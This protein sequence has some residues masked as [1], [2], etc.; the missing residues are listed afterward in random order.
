MSNQVPQP[1]PPADRDDEWVA[2]VIAL[3]ALA[4]LLGWTV[5][6]SPWLQDAQPRLQSRQLTEQ[7]NL[8]T[9]PRGESPTPPPLESLRNQAEVQRQSLP[10]GKGP[11]DSGGEGTA[12]TD[13]SSPLAITNAS[14][15]Q[16]EPRSPQQSLTVPAPSVPLSE[17]G[18][19]S[20]STPLTPPLVFSDLP[21]DYWAK[22][23]IDALTTRGILAGFP[24]GTF[25]P[26]Q[27]MTRAELAAQLANAFEFPIRS[28]APSAFV[29]IPANYWATGGIQK[30]V[31]TGFMKGYPNAVFQPEQTVPRVQV[32][33]AI[34]AGLQLQPADTVALSQYQDQAEIPGWAQE[35]IAAAIAAGIITSQS[36]QT[37]LRPNQPATRAEVAAMLYRALIYL[38]ELPA[39]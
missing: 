32:I 39:E 25:G 27:A 37:E 23:Y 3:G 28:D 9:K 8:P 30:A 20:T 17:N 21:S 5:F 36:N 18:A 16:P 6:Q 26:D 29:D 19:D 14:E 12:A 2:V 31:M 35:K 11:D 10:T 24:D 38:G 7:E 22:P 4:G 13:E 34:A 15:P 33:A 1:Q